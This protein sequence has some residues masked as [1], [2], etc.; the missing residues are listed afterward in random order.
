M[1][2]DEKLALYLEL[3]NSKALAK[4]IRLAG[5]HC[6]G[7]SLCYSSMAISNKLGWWES[8]IS[9]VATWNGDPL[10]LNQATHLKQASNPHE[11]L[12][13]LFQRIINYIL[14]HQA[15]DEVTEIFK[16]IEQKSLLQPGKPYFELDNKNNKIKH[17]KNMMGYFTEEDLNFIITSSLLQNNIALIGSLNHSCAMRYVQNQWH[18]F[19]SNHSC[20]RATVYK[21]KSAFIKRILSTLGNTLDICFASSE[22]RGRLDFTNYYTLLENKTE[23]LLQ[24]NSF[25]FFLTNGNDYLPIL[26]KQAQ[27]N[28]NI[29]K[30]ILSSLVAKHNNKQTGLQN[31]IDF[32]PENL[33]KL[34]TLFSQNLIDFDK[35]I[36]HLPPAIEIDSAETSRPIR[37]IQL[38]IE[39]KGVLNNKFISRN[40]L[41]VLLSIRNELN[42]SSEYDS[43]KKIIENKL[44]K[45]AN[46]MLPL[47]MKMPV[48]NNKNSNLNEKN[49]GICPIQKLK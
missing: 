15:T 24:K 43:L 49:E 28:P 18:F 45:A 11:T 25:N 20:A 12:D 27:N 36:I 35:F 34:I 23:Q 39:L 22:Q 46:S 21:T 6:F 29:R 48:I 2:L 8:A 7:Y 13:F 41:G 26:L 10:A 14:F 38:F 3:N 44:S 1:D 9:K 17:C 16:D 5:G 19:D 33:K 42:K 47:P 31:M 4:K 37:L 32:S 40:N 30:E